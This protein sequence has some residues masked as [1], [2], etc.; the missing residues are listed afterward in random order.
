MIQSATF[1]KTVNDIKNAEIESVSYF[2]NACK[3]NGRS[4]K[5]N[6]T[7]K[8]QKILDRRFAYYYSATEL[9]DG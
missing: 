8:K 1:I 5:I 6:I 7:V 3:I 4:F 9:G 2:E